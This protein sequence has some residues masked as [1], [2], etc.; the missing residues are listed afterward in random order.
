MAENRKIIGVKNHFPVTVLVVPKLFWG[1]TPKSHGDP[2][3]ATS[4]AAGAISCGPQ[5]SGL[6]QDDRLF[7]AGQT[8]RNV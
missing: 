6:A 5:Y 1:R 8:L 4:H 7:Q 3:G 2:R